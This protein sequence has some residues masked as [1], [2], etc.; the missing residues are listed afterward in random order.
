V[1]GRALVFSHPEVVRLVRQSFVAYAGD[2]WYLHRRQDAAGLFFWKVAQQGHNKA[3]PE[4]QTRQGIYAATPD[5]ELLGSLNSWSAAKTVAM[6][7]SAGEQWAQRSGRPRA[8]TDRREGG[9]E[10]GSARRAAHAGS[11]QGKTAAVDARYVREPPADGLILDVF[12][13]I[14]QEPAGGEWSLNR[15]TGR[16][17]VWLTREEWRSLLPADW[18]TGARY[19]VPRAVAERLIRFHLVDNVRGE[20]PMWTRSEIREADLTLIVENADAGRIRLE[21][22]ARMQAPS[23]DG[24]AERGYDARLQGTLAF[25]RAAGHWT[26]LDI[27][28]WGEAWGEGRYTPG[29]PAGRFPLVIAISLAGSAPAD[30]VPPQGSRDL[31][32]YFATGR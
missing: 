9:P 31:A 13:R 7:R 27:L 18:K 6:L 30:R 15:A 29:A 10:T 4:D 3:L 20:P 1:A 22:T 19:P 16:D 21:G 26:Q 12:S 17:H 11:S 28:A 24:G 2:Q 8:H 25:D 5:G 14:P 23:N 32:A